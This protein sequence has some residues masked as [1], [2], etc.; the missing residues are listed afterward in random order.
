[1]LK[2]LL[3]GVRSGSFI[4]AQGAHSVSY[5]PRLL[6]GYRGCAESLGRSPRNLNYLLWVKSS[7]LDEQCC[8][9]YARLALTDSPGGSLLM[10]TAQM[11]I[12]RGWI[13]TAW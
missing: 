1:M 10:E 11:H 12:S 8:P 9:R 4:G 7:A 13:R 2:M 6:S 5:G 3:L